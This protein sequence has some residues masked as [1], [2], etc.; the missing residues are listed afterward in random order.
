MA[1]EKKSGGFRGLL[2]SAASAVGVEVVDEVPKEGAKA[3]PTAP[4]SRPAPSPGPSATPPAHMPVLAP[5][6]PTASFTD[7]EMQ[8]ANVAVMQVTQL[9]SKEA[10]KEF[11]STE[12]TLAE[13]IPDD[14]K[15][16]R[17]AARLTAKSGK[18]IANVIGEATQVLQVAQQAIASADQAHDQSL[19]QIEDAAKREQARLQSEIEATQRKMADLERELQEKRQGLAQIEQRAHEQ[20]TLAARQNGAFKSV[21][22]AT[23]QRFSSLL[24]ALQPTK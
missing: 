12:R 11:L 14:A 6:A 23:V 2:R 9:G 1:E 20:R 7:E 16:F 19:A 21:L 17:S 4:A 22:T 3:P 13:D 15:R 10:L 24:T 18:P 8:A 5:L